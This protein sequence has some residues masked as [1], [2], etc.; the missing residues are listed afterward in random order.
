ML[1]KA[2]KV[3]S[4]KKF[5]KSFRQEALIAKFS[6]PKEEAAYERRDSLLIRLIRKEVEQHFG[7]NKEQQ[8]FVGDDWWPDHTRHMEVTPAHCTA[9]FLTA[10]RRL[11]NNDY[12]DYRIQICVYED[13]MDGTTYI[14]SMALYTDRVLIEKRLHEL[15]QSGAE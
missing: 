1:P 2:R 10:L 6:S 5:D 12:K 11:L 13:P 15:L 4:P 3:V 7:R 14:G 9:A 8:P